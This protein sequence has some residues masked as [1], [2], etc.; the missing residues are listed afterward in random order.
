MFFDPFST[1]TEC[2]VHGIL[3]LCHAYDHLKLFSE[4]LLMMPFL[5]RN[6]AEARRG[7]WDW[8]GLQVGWVVSCWIVWAE[9]GPLQR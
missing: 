5:N 7:R 1:Y 8:P 4:I 3:F 2:I 9:I 6:W